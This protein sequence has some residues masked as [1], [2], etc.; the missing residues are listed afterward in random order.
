[1]KRKPNV[2]P[3]RAR[4][5]ASCDTASAHSTNTGRTARKGGNVS[6]GASS[7]SE[8]HDRQA[9]TDAEVRTIP[10]LHDFGS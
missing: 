5:S 4:R 8:F 7:N 6:A 3:S 9:R 1:M 2:L 10:G